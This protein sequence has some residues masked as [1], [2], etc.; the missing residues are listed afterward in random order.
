MHCTCLLLTQS[1][2][3]RS[4]LIGF[5]NWR[6]PKPRGDMMRR[7]DFIKIIAGSATMWPL[8]TG[9]QQSSKKIPVLVGVLWHAGNAEEEEVYL[10]VVRKAFN[11][12]GYIEGKNIVLEQRFPAVFPAIDSGRWRESLLMPNPTQLFQCSRLALELK[13][14]TDTIPIVFVLMA[15]PAGFGLV[16]SSARPG[17][18][19]TGPSLM[20]IDVSGKRLELFKEAV[21]NCCASRCS[22]M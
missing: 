19:A 4:D 2:H 11:D 3:R 21:P 17:G 10:S 22:R 16:R 5:E 7:R 20:T 13:K 12:L 18:N 15:D 8:A 9:A 6:R 1:G 14:L